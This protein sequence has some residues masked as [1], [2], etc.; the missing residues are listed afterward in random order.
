M[1]GDTK[2]ANVAKTK[3][4][5][6]LLEEQIASGESGNQK[7][8]WNIS[9]A[10]VRRSMTDAAKSGKFGFKYGLGGGVLEQALAAKEAGLSPNDGTWFIKTG[11]TGHGRTLE[12]VRGDATEDAWKRYEAG[13]ITERQLRVLSSNRTKKEIR[14]AAEKAAQ[15]VDEASIASTLKG[16]EAKLTESVDAFAKERA[17]AHQERFYKGGNSSSRYQAASEWWDKLPDSEKSAWRE[18]VAPI[19]KYNDALYMNAVVSGIPA[20]PDDLM[21]LHHIL[22]KE[23]SGSNNPRQMIGAIGRSLPKLGT[24]HAAQHSSPGA[25]KFYEFIES[26][27]GTELYYPKVS[28]PPRSVGGK[29][30][31]TQG[32][33]AFEPLF[34][35]ELNPGGNPWAGVSNAP[36]HRFNLVNA[37]TKPRFRLPGWA[38]LAAAPLVWG[39]TSMLPGSEA[40][41]GGVGENVRRNVSN[42]NWWFSGLTGLPEDFLPGWRENYDATQRAQGQETLSEGLSRAGQDWRELGEGILNIPERVR[43]LYGRARSIFD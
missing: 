35:A 36:E 28:I 26:V 41:A 24:E 25:R 11:G 20:N 12:E 1:S 7:Q 22:P 16:Q 43:N 40:H 33:S 42:P 37:S 14:V 38:G 17:I 29:H 27:G 4:L 6:K 9:N 31:A 21:Q 30:F 32:A 18:L 19:K 5:W 15:T 39:A 2:V 23:F 10:A 3:Y 13:E 8:Q 34:P